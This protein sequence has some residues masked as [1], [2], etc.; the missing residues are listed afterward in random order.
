MIIKITYLLQIK[1]IISFIAEIPTDTNEQDC[2]V[3]KDCVGNCVQSD[4]HL[5]TESTTVNK[6][7]QSMREMI[8]LLIYI[9]I[10]VYV[11]STCIHMY[12]YIDMLV[13][14]NHLNIFALKLTYFDNEAAEIK[15][16]GHVI[17]ARTVNLTMQRKILGQYASGITKPLCF[18]FNHWPHILVE[19]LR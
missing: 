3:F 1:S 6:C 7:S 10:H 15:R 9:Y 17:Y 16:T 13:H 19:F 5:V 4:H 11:L 8:Y 2:M 14:R 12:T 18:C